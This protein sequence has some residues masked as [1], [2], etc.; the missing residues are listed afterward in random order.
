[1]LPLTP[2]IGTPFSCSFAGVEAAGGDG[3]SADLR[4]PWLYDEPKLV[5]AV[6]SGSSARNDGMSM[7]C[8]M[9]VS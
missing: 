2:F 7:E 9:H 4:S 3:L 6:R 1:M 5:K 8:S